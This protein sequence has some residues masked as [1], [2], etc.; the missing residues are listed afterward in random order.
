MSSKGGEPLKLTFTD[1]ARDS[2]PR[3]SPDGKKVAFN[4]VI[5]GVGNMWIL[6]LN[7]EE[8]KKELKLLNE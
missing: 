5:S 3:F 8:I 4:R 2:D 6:E 1:D 7:T